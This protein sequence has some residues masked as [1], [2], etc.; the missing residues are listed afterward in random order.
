MFTHGDIPLSLGPR[1]SVGG[2]GEVY[3]ATLGEREVVAKVALPGADPRRLEA[4][5]AALAAV[6]SPNVVRLIE[7]RD[8]V[9]ILERINGPTVELLLS[10]LRKRGAMPPLA[11]VAAFALGLLDGL[12][13]IHTAS[14]AGRPLGLL[15]RD[16][17]ARNVLIDRSGRPVLIDLGLARSTLALPSTFAG[18]RGTLLFMAPEQLRAETAGQDS[19]VFAAALLIYELLTLAETGPDEA[20]GLP[21]LLAMRARRLPPASD[22]RPEVNAELSHALAGALEPDRGARTAT[23]A[24]LRAALAGALPP[25]DP[26]ALAALVTACPYGSAAGPSRKHTATVA[27][28]GPAPARRA[29][30]RWAFG[31]ATAVALGA[32]FALAPRVEPM[33]SPLATTTSVGTS[34]HPHRPLAAELARPRRSPSREH[35]SIADE[36]R[37][38]RGA[39]EE[40][41]ASTAF[42]SVPPREAPRLGSR[43]TVRVTGLSGP[44]HV[45]GAGKRALAPFTT[46]TLEAPELLTLV[47]GALRLYARL[48]PGPGRVAV[49]FTAPDDASLEVRCGRRGGPTP[50]SFA[51]ASQLDCEATGPQGRLAFRLERAGAP[52]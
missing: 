27:P 26:A 18:L 11:A 25:S 30:R 31:A 8:D 37:R 10:D 4:E 46:P 34:S 47:G 20:A 6:K 51:V 15:H 16:V 13:A 9:L 3:L 5:R 33:P 44:L 41:G 38:E 52:E 12:T 23:A 2:M 14:D 1:L 40:G 19:D 22:F 48:A 50:L 17:S 36:A 45:T 7:A 28:Q 42:K 21:G 49:R 39:L 43:A 32:T 35:R 24:A 29:V